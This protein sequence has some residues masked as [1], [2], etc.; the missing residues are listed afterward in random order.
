MSEKNNTIATLAVW[1]HGGPGTALQ[2]KGGP[3]SPALVQTA[4]IT[5]SEML[6]LSAA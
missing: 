5:F 3:P 6:V 4:H 1:K 2:G